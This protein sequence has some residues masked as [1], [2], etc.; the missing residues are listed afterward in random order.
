MTLDLVVRTA[1]MEAVREVMRELRASGE[2]GPAEPLLTKKQAA[3]FTGVSVTTLDA[4]EKCG[5]LDVHRRERVV[6]YDK[7]ALLRAMSWTPPP[8][9]EADIDT[10]ADE[11]L[12]K[13]TLRR[14]K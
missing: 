3:A 11:L 7:G 1:V 13:S 10:K 5:A 8:S 9:S 6:R 4:W 2:L 12:A 14:V